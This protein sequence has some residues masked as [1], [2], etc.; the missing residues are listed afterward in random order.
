MQMA[1]ADEVLVTA[2]LYDFIRPLLAAQRVQPRGEV[3][4]RGKTEAVEVYSVR[5]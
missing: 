5:L 3:A 1:G 4:L 2:Q